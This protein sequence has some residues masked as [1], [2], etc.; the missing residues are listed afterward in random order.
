MKLLKT[1]LCVSLLTTAVGAQ[2]SYSASFS[3]FKPVAMG[4]AA[5]AAGGALFYYLS[6]GKE[7]KKPDQ[8][9]FKR[10]DPRAPSATLPSPILPQRDRIPPVRGYSPRVLF[11]A[12]TVLDAS[13]ASSA[14]ETSGTVESD[15]EDDEIIAVLS[16]PR[17]PEIP[18]TPQTPLLKLVGRGKA[19][20]IRRAEMMNTPGCASPT[21]FRPI[22]SEES[23]EKKV[24]LSPF[25]LKQVIYKSVLEYL[26]PD[27]L[28]EIYEELTSN[29]FEGVLTFFISRLDKYVSD[30]QVATYYLFLAALSCENDD[31]YASVFPNGVVFDDENAERPDAFILQ[32]PKDRDISATNREEAL[33][34]AKKLWHTPI[35]DRLGAASA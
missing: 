3:D 4:V 23:S 12:P 14:A 16:V 2:K 5:L 13:V 27:G 17:E 24:P 32:A 7:N 21:R 26:F 25:K 33:R 35:M 28:P 15:D 6:S 8:S 10:V 20:L 19:N 1:I 9:A 22:Q 31:I 34:V 11:S 29:D 30:D 18:A